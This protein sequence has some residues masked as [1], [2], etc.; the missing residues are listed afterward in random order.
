MRTS[1]S[2]SGSTAGCAR[3]SRYSHVAGDLLA[4]RV[5][6]GVQASSAQG[7]LGQNL[8]Q[9]L[10]D[11]ARTGRLAGIVKPPGRRDRAANPVVQ[12]PR[13]RERGGVGGQLGGR[14]DGRPARGLVGDILDLGGQR[15]ICAGD[16]QGE[17][18][19]TLGGFVDDAAELRMHAADV[20]GPGIVTT[21]RS[22]ERVVELDGLAGDPH[23]AGRL[24][25]GE[26]IGP[27]DPDE[28]VARRSR[29]QGRG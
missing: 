26:S 12:C 16:G 7:S 3:A 28:E 1:S 2:T 29:Q 10:E 13:R 17:M 24:Q 25:V 14:V 8:E 6:Q 4:L 11:A 15:L 22:H 27:A 19:G 9:G 18:A 5:R 21:C 23:D 20:V